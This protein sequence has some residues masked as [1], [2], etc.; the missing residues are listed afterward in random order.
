MSV[1]E[2]ICRDEA[3]RTVFTL[4]GEHDASNAAELTSELDRA[5]TV[6]HGDLVLDLS[7]VE[8]M[9]ASTVGVIAHT[10]DAL[11]RQHRLLTVQ[12]PTR[13]ARRVL[14]ICGLAELTA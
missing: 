10:R 5:L 1:V 7:E 2:S 13:C 9:G 11:D 8:F 6:A 4:R 3:G 14:E 12:R